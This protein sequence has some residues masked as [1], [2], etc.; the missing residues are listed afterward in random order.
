MVLRYRIPSIEISIGTPG[1][2]LW[3]LM[4]FFKKAD[5]KSLG[6]RDIFVACPENWHCA[7]DFWKPQESW[8]KL[9][10]FSSTSVL[11]SF[12]LP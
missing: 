1:I 6:P 4:V 11:L 12:I 5:T 9:R 7:Q 10:P 2:L 8:W 3:N